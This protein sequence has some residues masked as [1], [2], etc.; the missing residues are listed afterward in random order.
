M[1]PSST[2]LLAMTGPA[3]LRAMARAFANFSEFDRFVQG[4]QAALDQSDYFG[5]LTIQIDRSMTEPSKRFSAGALTLPLA[6]TTGKLG[7]LQV[8]ASEEFRQF[9]AHDL[10]LMAGLADFLSVAL[11]QSL[12]LEAAE[13]SPALLRFLL[14]QAPVGIA[15]YEGDGRLI[16]ANELAA[17]WLRETTVPFVQLTENRG[18]F[19]LRASGKLIYGEARRNGE[20]NGGWLVVLQDLT[21]EQVRLLELFGSE[22]YRALAEGGRVGFA[23][24]ES[25]QPQEGVLRRLPELRAALL[26]GEIAGPYDAHRVGLVLPG[27]E[28]LALR[29]R[30]RKLHG[31]FGEA[32]GL[33]LGCAELGRDGRTPAAL[34]EAALKNPGLFE[35]VL[36]PSLLVHDDS[37]AVADTLA[38]ILGKEFKVVKS[39]SPVRTRAL[40]TDGIFEGFVTELE[41]RNGVNGVELVNY[42]RE[43]QPGIRPFFTTV[44][45]IPY[46]LPAGVAETDATVL[47]KPFDIPTLT[48]IVRTKLLD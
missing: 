11:A 44:Q 4:L 32:P 20:N 12:R 29:A 45:R 5:R 38:M 34:L 31:V 3:A 15:A 43:K 13:K 18:C 40:L 19:H 9:G 16:V 27:V 37:A 41:L 6:S 25:A 10:H 39:T 2:T 21:A 46:G 33:R 24:I 36:R 7:T 14:D 26:P 42:A 35:E 28:G 23:L 22:T 17:R 48:K 47:E 8:A 30:L 1:P